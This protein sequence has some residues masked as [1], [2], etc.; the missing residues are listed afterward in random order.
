MCS[1]RLEPP[2]DM[3]YVCNPTSVIGK[4]CA[5]PSYPDSGWCYCRHW[6]C[7]ESG[8]S[9]DCGS[10]NEGGMPGCADLYFNCC[11]N[12]TGTASSCWCDDF[13]PG[14]NSGWTS[15]SRCHVDDAPCGAGEVE[16][17]TCMD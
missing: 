6:A 13:F 11:M 5:D 3:V 12:V 2:D 8:G 16:V 9:C 7:T 14:C 15:V 17:A 1:W 4:C 10:S